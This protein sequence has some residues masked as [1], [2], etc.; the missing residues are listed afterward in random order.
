MLNTPYVSLWV[1]FISSFQHLTPLYFPYI[2]CPAM[3]HLI[4][5][6]RPVLSTSIAWSWGFSPSFP[7]SFSHLAE[8]L[9]GMQKLCSSLCSNSVGS[10]NSDSRPTSPFRHHFLPHSQGKGPTPLL[11]AAPSLRPP[12]RRQHIIS[13]ITWIA[14]PVSAHSV[15]LDPSTFLA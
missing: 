1:C 6:P 9:T 11:S 14:T 10:R 15:I 7:H 5:F 12:S 13:I 2:V 3:S 8:A 4:S